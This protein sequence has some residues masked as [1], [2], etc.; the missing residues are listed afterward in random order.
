VVLDVGTGSGILAIWSA[1]AGARKVYAVEATN[2]AEHARELVRAN[3]VADIVEV[4]QGTM[5]DIV[6]PEKGEFFQFA[7]LFSFLNR[8]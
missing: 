3:G 7:G 4:I 8:W 1:Q 2:V 6:L 5:E